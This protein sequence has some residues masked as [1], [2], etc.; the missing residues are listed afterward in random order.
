MA[1]K[2][3]KDFDDLFNK[4]IDDCHFFV[5]IRDYS[6]AKATARDEGTVICLQDNWSFSSGDLWHAFGTLEK[7]RLKFL[8]V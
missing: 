1:I 4:Y 2:D 7:V 8:K 6:F 3:S 5:R